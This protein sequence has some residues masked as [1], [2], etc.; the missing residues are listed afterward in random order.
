VVS[1]FECPKNFGIY[2]F[3]PVI[4]NFGI[5]S[6]DIDNICHKDLLYQYKDLIIMTTTMNISLP[7]T[8]KTFVDNTIVT[9]GYGTA[10][11]Y[12]R[13]LIRA[14][15]KR[16]EQE[17]LEK[18]LLKALDGEPGELNEDVWNNLK[19]KVRS[20]LEKSVSRKK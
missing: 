7:E 10:S 14:D 16:K 15:Q 12:V 13:E 17:K 20:N 18:V 5:Y 1:N 9:E 19:T 3:C 11:E 2:S 6:K 4:R 8:M